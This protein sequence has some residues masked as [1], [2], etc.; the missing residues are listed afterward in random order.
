M[1]SV[2]RSMETIVNGC[3][4]SSEYE[5]LLELTVTGNT[6]CAALHREVDNRYP[7]ELIYLV[8]RTEDCLSNG[9]MPLSPSH[10]MIVPG[11]HTVHNPTELNLFMSSNSAKWRLHVPVPHSA[12]K[13]GRSG[14]LVGPTPTVRVPGIVVDVDLDAGV[15]GRVGAGEAD[16]VLTRLG[17]GAG[18]VNSAV[19]EMRR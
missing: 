11:I 13:D 18:D 19:C 7:L 8:K 4:C 15:V 10:T 1:T 17:A 5:R 14:D 6:A 16:K 3:C 2:E 9:L 12:S